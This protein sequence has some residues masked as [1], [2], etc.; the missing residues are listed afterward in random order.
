MTHMV[1]EQ[2]QSSLLSTCVDSLFSCFNSSWI[3]R[4]VSCSLAIDVDVAVVVKV[5]HGCSNCLFSVTQTVIE[6]LLLQHQ[7]GVNT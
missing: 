5:T 4:I 2:G 1:T 3:K 6:S 7:A